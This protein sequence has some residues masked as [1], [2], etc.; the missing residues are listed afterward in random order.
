MNFKTYANITAIENYF[1]DKII[2]YFLLVAYCMVITVEKIVCHTRNT[3][4]LCVNSSWTV[5]I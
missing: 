2:E 3:R 1:D 4:E 5:F